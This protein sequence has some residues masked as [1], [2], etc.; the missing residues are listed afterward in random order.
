METTLE[1]IRERLDNLKT[2]NAQEHKAILEQ[3]TKTNGS[4]ADLVRWKEKTTGA[5]IVINIF[6]IPVMIAIAIKFVLEV[7]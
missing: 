3:T 2:A 7:F 4:V 6:V 5:L 1:V